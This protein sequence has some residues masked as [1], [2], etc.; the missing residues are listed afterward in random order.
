MGSVIFVPFVFWKLLQKNK[1]LWGLVIIFL[2][3]PLWEQSF[4]ISL[5]WN[6]CALIYLQF[7][8]I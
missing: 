7:F 1:L 2:N 3:I 4:L 8:Y 6:S 5:H